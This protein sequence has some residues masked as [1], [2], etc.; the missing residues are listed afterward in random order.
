M[1]IKL[2]FSI[3]FGAFLLI[4]G[5]KTKDSPP[6]PQDDQLQLNQVQ[7]IG[8]HNSYH[9]H[10][11]DT[12]FAFLD[13]LGSLIPANYD[14]KE[15]D[16]TNVPLANQLG[17]YG[18]RGLEIDIY[19]DPT[20]G[21]FYL[22]KINQF[23]P[24]ND[25]SFIPELLLPG[26]KVLHIK[27]VD[28]NSTNYT[29]KS[30]LTSIKTWSDAHPNHLPIFINIETKEDGPAQN[31]TLAGLGFQPATPF[32]A[33]A[34]DNIDLEIKSV[35]GNNLDHVLTPDKIRNGLPTLNDVV[36]QKKWPKLGQC[37]G[38]VVFIMEG[39]AAALYPTGHPSLEGRAM[40]IYAT[41]GTPEAAFLLM[42]DAVGQ[43]DSIKARVRDGYIVRTRADGG[44]IQARTGDYSGMNAAFASG[45]QVT[46]TDYYRPDPR[47]AISGSGWTNY[48]VKFPNGEIGRKNII[49]ADSVSVE[50][51]LKE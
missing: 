3:A 7:I 12:I 15:L 24:I 37:R 14:P 36:V 25:T 44:T 5:C 22:R 17:D 1:N 30:A 49:N 40:F 32:D 19:N 27:D 13:S 51:T 2:S 29:F 41:Q 38:K 28:Y 48:V 50:S 9:I 21:Q 26:F 6:N 11:S 45:A 16:Y 31:A 39:P 33:S 18:M 46:S 42:N 47:G 4:A 8:S 35:F 34:C 43:I 23:I 20:G 10:P